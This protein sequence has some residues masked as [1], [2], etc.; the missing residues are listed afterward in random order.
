MTVK[1]REIM[2][3]VMTIVTITIT[4]RT[5]KE[6]ISMPRMETTSVVIIAQII[7]ASP[8]EIISRKEDSM[9]I[10]ERHRHRYQHQHRFQR[11]GT[12]TSQ[13][14]QVWTGGTH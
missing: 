12:I 4:T 7:E 5:I 1:G 14:L 11:K 10:V 6:V 3:T 13:V 2:I 8:M 9:M